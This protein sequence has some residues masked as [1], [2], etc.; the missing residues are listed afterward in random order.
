MV[1]DKCS[2]P[3]TVYLTVFAA[4]SANVIFKAQYF[5][6]GPMMSYLNGMYY[7]SFSRNASHMM[8]SVSQST[9]SH[10]Y[11]TCRLHIIII[12]LVNDFVISSH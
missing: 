2:D 5:V 9:K 4:Q 11:T 8:F 1:V 7:V 3:V 12:I 6:G 10:I